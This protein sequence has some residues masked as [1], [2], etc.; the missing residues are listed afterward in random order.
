[1]GTPQDATG[2]KWTVQNCQD[3]SCWCDINL[4][5]SGEEG[6]STEELLFL[7]VGKTVL[8]QMVPGHVRKPAKPVKWSK[9]HPA[10]SLP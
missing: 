2:W 7:S 3:F 5:S 8:R 6:T 10:Y 4:E 9:Q 1:M